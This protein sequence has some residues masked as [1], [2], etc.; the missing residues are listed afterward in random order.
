MR[1]SKEDTAQSRNR[2]TKAAAR[3]F[4]E[5]GI[6][7]TGVAEV[8][9]TAG[10]THGGFYRHFASKEAL[11]SEAVSSAVGQTIGRLDQLEGKELRDAVQSY[12][13]AY[14]SIGHVQSPG[15]GCPIAATGDEGARSQLDI[16]HVYSAAINRL[17]ASLRTAL[18]ERAD[19]PETTAWQIVSQIVGA[20][21]VARLLDDPTQIDAVLRAALETKCVSTALRLT[22]H[23]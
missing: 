2:I 9:K 5:N 17:Q 8:M 16:R 12:L 23:Q 18:E 7:E 11:V 10:M 4:R 15:L 20:V 22:D 13:S 3:M 6:A 19:N 14:L 1:R 21:T